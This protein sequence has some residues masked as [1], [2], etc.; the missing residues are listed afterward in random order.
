MNKWE[1]EIRELYNGNGVRWV[2]PDS[3]E[4]H[5]YKKRDSMFGATALSKKFCVDRT[6]IHDVVNMRTWKGEQA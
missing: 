6:T 2:Y 5:I 3:Y 1:S 4:A